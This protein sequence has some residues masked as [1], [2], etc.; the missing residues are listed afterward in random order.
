[1]KK[2]VNS[3]ILSLFTFQAVETWY[4]YRIDSVSTAWQRISQARLPRRSSQLDNLGSLPWRLRGLSCSFPAQPAVTSSLACL[5]ANA[6]FYPELILYHCCNNITVSSESEMLS[7]G[8]LRCTWLPILIPALSFESVRSSVGV[9]NAITLYATV[10]GEV[11][12]NVPKRRLHVRARAFHMHICT[13]AC[14]LRFICL[15]YS[16]HLFAPAL[17]NGEGKNWAVQIC[18]KCT[19]PLWGAF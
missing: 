17:S 9:V 16:K 3:F 14:Y 13:V 15:V 12:C 18:D 6:P 11:W 5:N 19:E 1:M 7:C 4:R 8:T 10:W 2:L